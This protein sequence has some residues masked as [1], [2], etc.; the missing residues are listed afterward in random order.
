MQKPSNADLRDDLFDGNSR[1]GKSDV[2]HDGETARKSQ[3]LNARREMETELQ[4]MRSTT[5]V[6]EESS[7]TIGS[8][9]EK[10]TFYGSSL[11]KASRTLKA[12]KTKMENDD[13]YIY[14]SFVFFLCVSGYVFLKRV[15]IIAITTWFA[16]KMYGVTNWIRGSSLSSHEIPITTTHSPIRVDT[17]LPPNERPMLAPTNSTR[18]KSK[19]KLEDEL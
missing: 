7:R 13:K 5:A 1:E 9:N 6:I 19:P 10:Y 12:L 3:L 14:Y 4:R 17:T 2:P 11:S 8:V 16:A 18:R 15:K